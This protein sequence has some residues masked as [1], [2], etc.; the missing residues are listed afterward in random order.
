MKKSAR[1][2]INQAARR[3]IFKSTGSALPEKVLDNFDLEKMV[4]TSDDW[5]TSRTGIK[6]RRIISQGQTTAS[7]ATQAAKQTLKRASLKGDDLDL[8]ICATVTT[9]MVFPSTACFIQDNLKNR[10]CFAYDLAAACCGFIYAITNAA[11][12]I[13][14]GQTQNALIIGA[15]TLSNITDYTDRS[16]C[17]LFGDGA[18]ALLL[19]SAENTDRG[20]LYS[21]MHADGSKWKPLYCPAYGSRHPVGKPLEDKSM[22]Y[23]RINGRE[24]YQLAVRRIVEMIEEVYQVCS[25]C[26]DDIAMIIP[27]QMNLRIMESTAK[28]L[29]LPMDKMYMNIEKYGNTSAASIAI[30]LDEALQ[31]G[32][33]K[34]GDLIILVAFGGGVTWGVNLVRL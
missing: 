7:L 21:S 3:A 17:I 22:I 23:M 1:V 12:M 31:N 34:S 16:N 5:I 6:Q 27:H 18:G 14:T 10:H 13:S 11:A 28:R 8:I 25:L 32:C 19:Q 29:N 9:E 4:D 24:I 15:E 26:N 33:V 30:A 2:D 20:V